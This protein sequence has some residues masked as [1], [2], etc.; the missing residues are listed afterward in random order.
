MKGR[1]LS[2]S[3][4]PTHKATHQK[5][6]PFFPVPPGG[7][8]SGHSRC[9]KST[10]RGMAQIRPHFFGWQR[11]KHT[12]LTTCLCGVRHVKHTTLGVDAL[13]TSLCG[14]TR[15]VL[16]CGCLALAGG[17]CCLF[18]LSPLDKHMDIFSSH[19]LPF[20]Q[21]KQSKNCFCKLEYLQE[22]Q[23]Q[24]GTGGEHR[25]SELKPPAKLLENDVI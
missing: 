10:R 25:T 13:T 9:G 19:R 11:V 2:A 24:L 14:K 12:R 22:Q 18:L 8:S 17:R 1:E 20:V 3:P 6:T 16:A 21:G 7:L 15:L 23:D 4:I 5:N